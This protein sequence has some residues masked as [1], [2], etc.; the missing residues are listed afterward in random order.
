[1]RRQLALAAAFALLST[2]VAAQEVQG[3]VYFFNRMPGEVT[4]AV[5][6]GPPSR[7]PSNRLL[8]TDITS[9]SHALKIVLPDGELMSET[10]F[11]EPSTSFA[12]AKGER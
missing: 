9:G 5:D 4:F 8:F 7:V 11:F 12:E 2:S 1:M 6:N 10:H 3:R